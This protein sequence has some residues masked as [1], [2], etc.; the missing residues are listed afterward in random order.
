MHC[1]LIICMVEYDSVWFFLLKLIR[2]ITEEY[3]IMYSKSFKPVYV[4]GVTAFVMALIMPGM[5][6]MEC[7]MGRLVLAQCSADGTGNEVLKEQ[8]LKTSVTIRTYYVKNRGNDNH[9]GLSDRTAW[10]TIAKVNSVIFSEGSTIL[11]KKGSTWNETLVPST[12]GTSDSPITYNC[13]GTGDYPR[14]NIQSDVSKG[15]TLLIAGKNN[16][17]IKN[18]VFSNGTSPDAQVRG[19]VEISDSHD[20]LFDNIRVQSSYSKAGIFIHNNSYNTTIRSCAVY[21]V[22]YPRHEGLVDGIGILIGGFE[23]PNGENYA[24]NR[25][26][27]IEVYDCEI[28]G[29]TGTG[30]VI[31]E[32][33]YNTI[34]SNTIHD[35]G[36]SGIWVGGITGVEAHDN[37]VEKND[38]FS[39]CQYQDDSYGIDFLRPG[40]DNIIRYNAVHDQFD[41]FNYGATREIPF[42]QG[43]DHYLG[44]GGIRFDG[45]VAMDVLV[46]QGNIA[47]NNLVYNNF[48]GIEVI[49][50]SNSQILN[51]TIYNNFIQGRA[52]ALSHHANENVTTITSGNVFVNNIIYGRWY[53]VVNF[54]TVD[55][56]IDHNLYYV[57]PDTIGAW[58]NSTLNAGVPDIRTYF[59]PTGGLPDNFIEWK[60]LGYDVNSTVSANPNFVNPSNAN[61]SLSPGSPAIDAGTLN[62]LSPPELWFDFDG[63][64]VPQGLNPDIGAC[65]FVY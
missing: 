27:N 22:E 43:L 20:I 41:V 5:A 1:V 9:D 40:N 56:V 21:D 24:A 32:S 30:I 16:L 28:T 35:N 14:I 34:R 61:F 57:D 12:S 54:F 59:Y 33:P 2:K 36:G 62:I 17:V 6:D 10:A 45:N 39:N 48:H 46:T 38:V 55:A 19:S 47:H 3:C 51:N 23:D 13:Y 26:R 50:F 8:A 37:I 44:T 52:F 7:M 25:P 31:L 64:S 11:L 49:Q 4:M 18:I 15:R 53:L 60:Q 58:A 63:I 65:E 29:N 42:V